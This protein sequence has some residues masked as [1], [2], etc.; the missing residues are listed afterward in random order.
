MKLLKKS[1]HQNIGNLENKTIFLRRSTRAITLHGEMI[2]LLY[3]KRYDDYSLPGGGLD[4]GECLISGMTR[5]LK[6]ETGAKNIRDVKEFGI[7]EEFRPWYKEDFDVQ[8]IVSYCYTCTIDKKLGESSLESYEISNGMKALWINIHDAISHNEEVMAKSNK[9][10]FS[11]ERETYLLD[12]IRKN[13]S[14]DR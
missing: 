1:I 5:E 11:I 6:E 3:T 4:E 7:Y 2:L 13:M 10:G 14:F 9:K 12:L 8:H